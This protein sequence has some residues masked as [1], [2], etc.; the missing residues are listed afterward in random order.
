MPETAEPIVPVPLVTVLHES[1]N[2]NDQLRPGYKKVDIHQV[3]F[4][5]IRIYTCFKICDAFQQN[6]VDAPVVQQTCNRYKFG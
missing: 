2:A 6:G 1:F 5:R 3:S 4:S